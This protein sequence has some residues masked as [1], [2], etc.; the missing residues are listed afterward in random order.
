MRLATNLYFAP[1][2]N[3]VIFSSAIDG[4]A[5]TVRQFAAL[6][7][8]K[9]GIKGFRVLTVTKS[10]ERL[11]S[12]LAA[13]AGSPE[14]AQRIAEMRERGLSLHAIAEALNEEGVPTPRGGARWRPSSVQSALGYRRPRPPA[15]GAPPVPPPP[16]A[17]GPGPGERA[18]RPGPGGRSPRP[19]PPR[20]G[21]GR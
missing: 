16:P 3:N 11:R 15:P 20:K 4:W 21:P 13:T 7:E 19:G 2:R 17:K 6:Y 18:P 10:E 14:L 5:F 9:L 8:K 12:L 1:E